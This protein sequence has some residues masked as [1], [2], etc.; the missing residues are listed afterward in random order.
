MLSFLNLS[1]CKKTYLQSKME[2]TSLSSCFLFLGFVVIRII[3]AFHDY[4]A[5]INIIGQGIL[6]QSIDFRRI[7]NAFA[8]GGEIIFFVDQAPVN[9]FFQILFQDQIEPDARASSIAFH[10]RMCDVHIN[11][12]SDNF[13]KRVFRHFFDI[14]KS[15]VQ[16]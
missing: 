5:I 16:T 15:S 4:L 2:T 14:R 10:K 6:Y 8:H 13:F 3:N 7:G 11:V 1:Q 9:A 12:F